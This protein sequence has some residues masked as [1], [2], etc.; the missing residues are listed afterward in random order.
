MKFLKFASD[1][2]S[3]DQGSYREYERHLDSINYSERPSR[4]KAH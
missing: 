1:G 2:R 3:I 4:Y